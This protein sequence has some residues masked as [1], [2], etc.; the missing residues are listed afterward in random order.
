MEISTTNVHNEGGSLSTWIGALSALTSLQ[1]ISFNLKGSIPSE[2]GLLIGLKSLFLSRNALTGSIPFELGRASELSSL[3]FS[4]NYL[5]SSIPEQ[6][7]DLHNLTLFSVYNNSLTG[8]ISSKISSLISLNMFLVHYNRLTGT[9][10]S[11]IGKLLQISF[12]DISANLIH[13]SI[14]SELYNLTKLEYL[15]M[16][17]N[18]IAGSLSNDISNLKGLKFLNISVNGLTGTIPSYL[19]NLSSILD[20]E[21]VQNSLVGPIPKELFRCIHLQFLQISENLLTGAVP[22]GIYSLNQLQVLSLG[23][24]SFDPFYISSKIS[25]F[26]KL[27]FLSLTQANII[28]SIPSDIYLLTQ[29]QELELAFNYINGTISSDIGY[30]R[31]LN[32]L[33]LMNNQLSGSIP[34]NLYSLS[35]LQYLKLANNQ[36]TGTISSS[37][38]NLSS[39]ITLTLSTNRFIGSMPFELGELLH[40]KALEIEGNLFTGSLPATLCGIPF[41]V[42]SICYECGYYGS[43][44]LLGCPFLTSVPYCIFIAP[45]EF[46]CLGSLAGEVSEIPNIHVELVNTSTSSALLQVRILSTNYVYLSCTAFGMYETFSS[47]LQISTVTT[48]ALFTN[49]DIFYP[50]DGLLPLTSYDVF[51]FAS[52]FYDVPMNF[53]SVN[54]TRLRLKTNCCKFIRFS[55]VPTQVTYNSTT[56]SSA[57]V[58]SL[59]SL[60]TLELTVISVVNDSRVIAVQKQILFN[61]Q[62]SSNEGSFILLGP[63]GVYLVHLEV[64]GPSSAEYNVSAAFATVAII[65]I[66]QPLLPPSLS[67]SILGDSGGNAFILFNAATDLAGILADEWTCSALFE[68]PSSGNSSCSWLNSSA[69]F[70]NFPSVWKTS[71]PLPTVDSPV[72]L[73]PG[74]IR[75]ACQPYTI[76]SANFASESQFVYLSIPYH[77]VVPAVVLNAPN[78]VNLNDSI[79]IDPTASSGAGGR[80]WSTVRWTVTSNG[81]FNATLFQLSYLDTYNIMRTTSTALIVPATVLPAANYTFLLFLENYLNISSSASVALSILPTSLVPQISILGKSTLSI[82]QSQVLYLQSVIQPESVAATAVLEF[83]WTVKENNIFRSDLNSQSKDP[84]IFKL[85]P[86]VLQLYSTYVITVTVIDSSSSKNSSA[87]VEVFVNPPPINAIIFGGSSRVVPTSESILLNASQSN[88]AGNTSGLTFFWSCLIVSGDLYGLECPLNVTNSDSIL[89]LPPYSL[90]EFTSYQFTV[91]CGFKQFSSSATVL[92]EV[93]PNFAPRVE[94]HAV[95]SRVNTPNIFI[96]TGSIFAEYNVSARWNVSTSALQIPIDAITISPVSRI[97]SL[98]SLRSSIAFSIG[99]ET[100]RLVRGSTYVFTIYT[101]PLDYSGLSSSASVSVTVNTLPSLGYLAVEPTIGSALS[102][103]FLVSSIGWIAEEGGYP[104]QYDFKYQQVKASE[105]LLYLGLKGFSTS[106]ASQL[107]SGLEEENYT[108]Y[109]S[110]SVYDSFGASSSSSVTSQVLP[111]VN[112]TSGSILNALIASAKISSAQKDPV[113]AFQTVNIVATSLTSNLYPQNLS[114]Q[115]IAIGTLCDS[116]IGIVQHQDNSTEF[117]SSVINALSLIYNTSGIVRERTLASCLSVLVG[118]SSYFPT[119]ISNVI[120]SS[121]ASQI[122]NILSSFLD[123]FDLFVSNSSTSTILST[124]GDILDSALSD[125]IAG[126]SATMVPGQSAINLTSSRITSAVFNQLAMDLYDQTLTPHSQNS[127][128]SSIVFPSSGL[129]SC[130]QSPS[131]YVQI[132]LSQWSS[133][134]LNS[135]NITTPLLRLYSPKSN[136]G[137]TSSTET[138]NFTMTLVFYAAVNFSRT[139][140]KLSNITYA[141]ECRKRSASNFV[142]CGCSLSSYTNWNATF[143]CDIR[144]GICGLPP[145]RSFYRPYLL[146]QNLSQTYSS[147]P[148]LYQYGAIITSIENVVDS[149]LTHSVQGNP[150][151]ISSSK[152]IIVIAIV[153]VWLALFIAGL[154]FFRR[155]DKLDRLFILYSPPTHVAKSA[156]LRASFTNTQLSRFR[157]RVDEA[158]KSRASFNSDADMVEYNDEYDRRQRW[159]NVTNYIL[160]FLLPCAKSFRNNLSIMIGGMANKNHIFINIIYRNFNSSLHS[161]VDALSSSIVVFLRIFT[162][163][164]TSIA[165]YNNAEVHLA[166][167]FYI[168]CILQHLLSG[169][170]YL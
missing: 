1:M 79:I 17:N 13:G 59:S 169:K 75:A 99:I 162:G 148:D 39:L 114:T 26:T 140:S 149:T 62:N 137:L 103:T 158:F 101:S 18:N 138:A 118:T 117:L 22:N 153:S 78:T 156:T 3:S 88:F 130:G 155:W 94:L 43:S 164:N 21:L 100:T 57:L 50:V 90:T 167:N 120:L 23:R 6:I 112:M 58:F 49:K 10:P 116:I 85:A 41:V 14:P 122:S 19:G 80:P 170:L 131:G 132:S 61:S 133:P 161:S 89:A 119:D 123:S 92:L 73:I 81:I 125:L 65:P 11:Q 152:S 47:V 168:Y 16:D 154:I 77:P 52:S 36:L 31:S 42:F 145:I 113:G 8:S 70:V 83:I 51:C 45:F 108:L 76:C 166:V 68:F 38:G 28:G 165:F 46:K 134:Y 98:S 142:P 35:L 53:S 60:P 150:F 34:S 157:T 136:Y 126:V 95:S 72:Y 163:K 25:N 96:I 160:C 44:S 144:T 109:L 86:I 102:T 147:A 9:I 4:N 97:F 64:T 5:T 66:L 151:T 135:S 37:L 93:I 129:D 127:S 87:S 143:S 105:Q 91:V 29:L 20:L 30:L 7:Y 139:V 107:P 2:I 12:L 69:V 48:P 146:S 63:P 74:L 141:P 24:N 106:V 67:F 121:T 104:L 15:A 40:L 111:I 82:L 32:F 71:L 84:R 110:S 54:S 124:F 128:Q 115:D 55:Y 27:T 159:I 56:R 33:D